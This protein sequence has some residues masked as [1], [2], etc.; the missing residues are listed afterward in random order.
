MIISLAHDLFRA[1]RSDNWSHTMCLTPE[2]LTRHLL[3]IVQHLFD[4]LLQCPYSQC[5]SPFVFAGIRWKVLNLLQPQASP[6]LISSVWL[7]QDLVA[8]QTTATLSPEQAYWPKSRTHPQYRLL[9]P[10]ILS[11]VV[12][13]TLESTCSAY[14]SAPIWICLGLSGVIVFSLDH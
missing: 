7:P 5:H 1:H 10:H 14:T 4:H 11:K 13:F 2:L 12:L 9:F 6:C 3:I 8:S